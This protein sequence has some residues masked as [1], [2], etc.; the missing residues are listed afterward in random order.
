MVSFQNTKS[1][2]TVANILLSI[3]D[4]NETEHTHEK[5][6]RTIEFETETPIYM[7]T[8]HNYMSVYN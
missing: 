7:I 5:E 1:H 3:W 4:L 2:Y 6:G 8:T